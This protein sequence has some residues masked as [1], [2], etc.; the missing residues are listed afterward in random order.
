MS[1]WTSFSS[2]L[3]PISRLIAYSVF[4]GLVIACRLADAPTSISPSSWYA[5]TDGV[6]RA[7]S[8][9]SMTLGVPP[10]MMATQ[11]LVVPRSMPMILPMIKTS[12]I[13]MRMCVN[14]LPVRWGFRVRQSTQLKTHLRPRGIRFGLALGHGH[15]RGPQHAIV[16]E[17]ALL[18]N[19]HHRV[20][21][22]LGVDH[23]HRLVPMRVV[24][25]A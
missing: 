13:R 7:P 14:R 4:L 21:G 9:F 16:D 2:N 23:L 15:Q 18:V 20:R 5:T 22:L 24:L 11:L 19:T 8:E 17:V 25:L 12:V 1:F 10:S 3:R 6:V